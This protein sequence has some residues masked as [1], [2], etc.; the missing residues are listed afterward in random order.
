MH[1]RSAPFWNSDDPYE[2]PSLVGIDVE[3]IVD[4]EL[5]GFSSAQATAKIIG[6]P[7]FVIAHKVAIACPTISGA[8]GVAFMHHANR[9]ERVAVTEAASSATQTVNGFLKPG[10]PL[11]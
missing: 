8:V 9:G 2:P 4:M 1:A 3:R 5:D 6:E 7:V 10:E 11:S